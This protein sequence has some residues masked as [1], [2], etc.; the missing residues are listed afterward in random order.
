[1]LSLAW[2]W[3]PAVLAEQNWMETRV[4]V[5]APDCHWRTTV[6]R[7][8]HGAPESA[9]VPDGLLHTL[10]VLT[11]TSPSIS[12]SAMGSNSL[13]SLPPLA[14]PPDFDAVFS[15]ALSLGSKARQLDARGNHTE[16]EQLL[17][18]ALELLEP[19]TPATDTIVAVLWNSL[20][21][22]YLHMG[23][24]D[25]AER[26]FVKSLDVSVTTREFK[27]ITTTREN[28]ARVSKAR[29]ELLKAQALRMLGAPDDMRV[30][31]GYFGHPTSAFVVD[32]RVHST[33]LTNVR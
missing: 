19:R 18:R 14:T 23:R 21:E 2:P 25:D 3:L 31:K 9:S 6:V 4:H 12:P 16:A 32:V 1:M 29:G 28:L 13:A 7:A 8:D 33:A 11:T 5:T 27:E 10:L 24:L 20:G 30:A 15:E 22:L 26:W 17:Y